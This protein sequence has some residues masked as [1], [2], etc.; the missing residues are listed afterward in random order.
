MCWASSSAN[1]VRRCS[2]ESDTRSS[3]LK[4]PI[5]CEALVRRREGRRQQLNAHRA[6]LEE[7]KAAGVHLKV[8]RSTKLRLP[9]DPVQLQPTVGVVDY[10]EIVVAST[11]TKRVTKRGS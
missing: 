8:F 9:M 10:R 4:F 3:L 1:S 5:A 7:A 6:E 2:Y 11:T